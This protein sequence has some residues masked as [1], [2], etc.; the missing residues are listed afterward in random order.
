VIE[1][2]VENKG[3]VPEGY[4]R[5]LN[6]EEERQYLMQS[7]PTNTLLPRQETTSTQDSGEDT[8]RQTILVSREWNDDDWIDDPEPNEH[9]EP[10]YADGAQ[11]VRVER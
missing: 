7:P 3:L 8:P 9:T 5:F 2:I 6:E 11:K 4:V 10:E 1:L